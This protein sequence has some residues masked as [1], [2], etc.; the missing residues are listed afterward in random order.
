[1]ALNVA[2][3]GSVYV[4]L[5]VNPIPALCKLLKGYCIV[6]ISEVLQ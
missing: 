1:M 3:L 4:S 6:F 5:N 2:P